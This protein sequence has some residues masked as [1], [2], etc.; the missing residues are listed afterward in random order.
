[1]FG[2]KKNDEAELEESNSKVVYDFETDDTDFF[3]KPSNNTEPMTRSISDKSEDDEENSEEEATQKVGFGRI[4]RIFFI[5]VVLSITLFALW[6]FNSPTFLIEEVEINDTTSQSYEEI[7]SLTNDLVGKNIFLED[8]TTL[9]N[10]I[11]NL[12]RVRKVNI[13]R[14]L[15]NKV[16][17]SYS[18]RQPYMMVQ[19]GT[20]YYILDKDGYILEIN[21]V[22]NVYDIP[23]VKGIM[24]EDDFS[25]DKISDT[26]IVKLKNIEY[27][28]ESIE[29]VEFG[30]DIAN[31]EYSVEGISFLI[32]NS[33]LTVKFG[34]IKKN[35]IN[36]K[37]LYLKEIITQSITQGYKGTLDISSDN[38]N[39]KSV[40]INNY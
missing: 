28:L 34:N 29:H 21:L 27:L 17:I 39:E 30:Y 5:C 12:S 38:Y 16:V 25:G 24:D 22:N 31:I 40:L 37:L 11:S 3:R 6:A 33:E 7:Y 20:E 19:R 10:E 1:M 35:Q 18:E 23:L 8:L 2:K 36:D 26:D 14:K 13:K 15:P 4:V 9:K 32:K